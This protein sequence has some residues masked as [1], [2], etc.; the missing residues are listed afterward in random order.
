MPVYSPFL[1]LAGGNSSKSSSSS[2]R[3]PVHSSDVV[4][5]SV[6]EEKVK[7]VGDVSGQMEQLW[8]GQ[9]MTDTSARMRFLVCRQV[10]RTFLFILTDKFCQWKQRNNNKDRQDASC[11]SVF[12]CILNFYFTLS[13]Q[14]EASVA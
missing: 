6:L 1:W 12:G 4:D 7:N 2:S 14:L 3:V 9:A 13:R 5:D 11:F 10:G 8:R